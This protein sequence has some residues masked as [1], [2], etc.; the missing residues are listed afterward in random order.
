MARS[1]VRSILQHWYEHT[2]CHTLF[3]TLLQDVASCMQQGY[4]TFA[5][6]A[7]IIAT[8]SCVG[9]LHVLARTLSSAEKVTEMKLNHLA[10]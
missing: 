1:H 3:A 10:P 5:T 7:C 6:W 2:T 8:V 4:Q 9:T